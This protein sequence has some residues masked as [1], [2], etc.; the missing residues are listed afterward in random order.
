[1]AV[2]GLIKYGSGNFLSVLNALQHLKLNVRVVEEPHQ[3]R[4]VDKIV[5]PGVGAF[6]ALMRN[7]EGKGFLEPLMAEVVDRRKPYLGICVGMQII[8]TLGTEF[9]ECSGLNFIKGT[10]KRIPAERYNL[11][12]PNVGWSDV[13]ICRSSPLFRDLGNSPCFYF[14]HSYYF[15]AADSRV[16]TAIVDYGEPIPVS[17]ERDNI[18]GVQFHPEKS[19]RDGL[20]L[21]KNFGSL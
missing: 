17:I 19:Q 15:D 1:M 20:R 5:L 4:T 16:V 21:L 14:V 9:T 6:G 2:I 7:L 10:V 13:S 3:L 12:L 8:A 11:R 18:F